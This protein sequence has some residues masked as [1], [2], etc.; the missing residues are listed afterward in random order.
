MTWF[1][2]TITGYIFPQATGKLSRILLPIYQYVGED[3]LLTGFESLLGWSMPAGFTL[4]AAASYVQGTIRANDEPLPFMPPLQG[5]LAIGYSPVDW[6]VEAEARMAGS[7]ERTGQFEQPTDGYAVLGLSG[8]LRLTFAGRLHVVTL[9]LENIGDTVYRNHLSR[10]KE[11]MPEA[12]RSL[13]A[14]YRVV[15]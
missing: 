13:R 2:N 8:G 5:R 4:E 10:V 14:T 15:F 3:A 1:R 12:G 9:H 6:F 11:I 7:Q